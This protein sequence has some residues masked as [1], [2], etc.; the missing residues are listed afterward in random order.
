MSVLRVTCTTHDEAAADRLIAAIG[1]QGFCHDVDEAI[2]HIDSRTHQYFVE[3]DGESVWLEVGHHSDG[4]AYLTTQNAGFPPAKLLS[5][6]QCEAPVTTETRGSDDGMG[7]ME[8]GSDD[9]RSTINGL[10][11]QLAL[12]TIVRLL[13]LDQF[14]TKE[15]RLDTMRERAV[16]RACGVVEQMDVDEDAR[17]KLQEAVT[18]HLHSLFSPPR[19]S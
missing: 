17:T 3:V 12:K 13:V 2:G 10:A 4:T 16:Q 5:L 11:D 8:S 9:N 14:A 19:A 1:G 15:G 6:A 18:R 7:W